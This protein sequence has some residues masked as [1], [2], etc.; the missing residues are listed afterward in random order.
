MTMSMEAVK[1]IELGSF[2]PTP[3]G[4]IVKGKPNFEEWQ[5]AG[6]FLSRAGK[7]VM[8]WIGDWLNYGE[9]RWGQKYK[10]AIEVTGLDYHTVRVARYVSKEF[11]S[12]RRRSLLSFGHHVEVKALPARTADDFLRDAESEDLS[13]KELRQRIKEWKQ[14]QADEPKTLSEGCTVDDLNKLVAAGLKFN[15]IYADPPWQYGNQG[16]RAAT[17]NHYETMAFEDIAALPVKELAGDKSHL[18]LW[19]TNGFLVEALNLI[20]LWG[21]E[22]KSTFVWVKPQLG[23]GNYWRCSHEIMLLGVKGG[24]TFPPTNVKSWLEHDRTQHSK[25]PEAVRLLIEKVSPGP[26]LELFGR[27][28]SQGW[29]IWGNEISKNLFEQTA[30]NYS[31][32]PRS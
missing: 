9:H 25:K 2:Q 17:D 18:H 32:L 22:F 12:D 21:F 28:I 11:E 20:Q 30:R 3:T 5:E 23:I 16:T 24:L 13:I 8:W 7:S 27:T 31:R 26:Y 15:C 4:L 10:E 14:Q 6:H 29:T 1:E 19:T